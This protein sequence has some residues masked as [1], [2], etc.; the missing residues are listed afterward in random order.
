MLFMRR[1]SRLRAEV[2]RPQP[3][4]VGE[5]KVAIGHAVGG[6]LALADSS[7]AFL[8]VLEASEYVNN[9]RFGSRPMWSC[10]PGLG[11]C[12]ISML[13]DI[14]GCE[15]LV[16]LDANLRRAKIVR[17]LT[18]STKQAVAQ[19]LLREGGRVGQRPSA[20]FAAQKRGTNKAGF[21]FLGR[22]EISCRLIILLDL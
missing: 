21:L 17:S 20:Q 19:E 4:R 8:I 13:R 15:A 14:W 6:V 7:V 18:G 3:H 22:R 2:S 10:L 16:L 12:G 5:L 9:S 11:T 1:F